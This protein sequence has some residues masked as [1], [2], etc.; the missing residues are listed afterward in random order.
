MVDADAVSAQSPG[1]DRLT[2]LSL[3][4]GVAATQ[5]V[6]AGPLPFS[7]ELCDDDQKALAA[8]SDNMMKSYGEIMS[9]LM[10]SPRHASQRLA[11]LEWLVGGAVFT[12]QYSL[13]RTTAP[14]IGLTVPIG[15]VFWARVSDDVDRR[16][17]ATPSVPAKLDF[18]DWIG[19]NSL[20]VIETIGEPTVVRD[21][22]LAASAK[23]WEKQPAKIRARNAEGD[24]I[25]G[26]FGPQQG[27][28][29][30]SAQ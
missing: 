25:V 24:L 27:T 12:G 15:A 16:L 11:D 20:W 10:R 28:G 2:D 3:D 26:L 18:K 13:A 14:G 22:L 23:R 29:D 30:P 21:M 1:G 5:L 19:G 6:A 8:A 4:L 7:P 17:S 9:L